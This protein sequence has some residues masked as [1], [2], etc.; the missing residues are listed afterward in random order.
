MH[1]PAIASIRINGG[2]LCLDFVNTA[3][4][5]DGRA[6]RDF[7]CNFSDLLTWGARQG[8]LDDK[9]VLRLRS[10]PQD[11]GATTVLARARELRSALRA[12]FERGAAA[13]R[14]KSALGLINV[15]LSEASCALAIECA[16]ATVRLARQPGLDDWLT[17]PLLVSALDLATS[18]ARSSVRVCPGDDCHWL[19]LDSSRNGTRRWCSM[20]SCGNKAKARAHYLPR[21]TG[22]SL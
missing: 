19:F 10:R 1:D 22:Y 16:G 14:V 5:A 15:R 2:R 17:A 8:L 3:T 4:W 20:E 12:L 18:P 6:D 7:L 13:S 11:F 9:D 21:R